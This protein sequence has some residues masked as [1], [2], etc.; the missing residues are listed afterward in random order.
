V[1]ITV[2]AILK[3]PEFMYKLSTVGSLPLLV[4]TWASIIASSLLVG[5]AV[6]GVVK[7]SSSHQLFRLLQSVGKLLA[8]SSAPLK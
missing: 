7:V 3:P 6:A 5:K 8:K 2:I 1:S 4:L